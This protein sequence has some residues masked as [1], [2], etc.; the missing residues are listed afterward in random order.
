[1]M[2]TPPQVPKPIIGPGLDTLVSNDT[3]L[4]Q[5]FEWFQPMS[6]DFVRF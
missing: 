4:F 6:G 1:M 2:C 5:W 3:A